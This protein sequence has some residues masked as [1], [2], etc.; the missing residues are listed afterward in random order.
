MGLYSGGLII[1]RTF[2]SEIWGPYFW[3]GLFFKG[4]GLIIGILRYVKIVQPSFS[5][6]VIEGSIWL[7]FQVISTEYVSKYK[8]N[9]VLLNKV[10]SKHKTCCKSNKMKTLLSNR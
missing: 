7:K 10:C 9:T 3:E 1:G 4:G 6:F 5:D 8:Y 2:V